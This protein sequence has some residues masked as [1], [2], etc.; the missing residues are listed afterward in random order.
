MF[1]SVS[2]ARPIPTG[3]PLFALI[4]APTRR[5][6]SQDRGP[7]GQAL[8]RPEIDPIVARIGDVGVR[9]GEVFP[10]LR[11]ERGPQREREHLSVLLLDRLHD[12]PGD[13]SPGIRTPPA[14]PGRGRDRALCRRPPRPRLARRPRSRSCDPRSLRVLFRAPHSFVK[15]PSNHGRS[16]ERNG[17]TGGS[18]VSSPRPPLP[19]ER[20]RHAAGRAAAAS[21]AAPETNSRREQTAAGFSLSRSS[22]G[23][24]GASL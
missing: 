11:I 24:P 15:T 17:S 10:G 22:E 7:S 5:S 9:E 13:P 18:S 19:G 1:E 2:C 20:G 14:A 8:L 3:M 4:R 16:R 21:A 6:S 23:E 12:R